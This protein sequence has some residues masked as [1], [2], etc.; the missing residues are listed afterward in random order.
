M[1]TKWF[2]QRI[3]RLHYLS[4]MTAK[5]VICLVVFITVGPVVSLAQITTVTAEQAPPIPGAGHDYIKL[6]NETVSPAVG[7]VDIRIDA[8][9]PLGRGGTVPFIIG[10]DTNSARHF[11]DG[12]PVAYDN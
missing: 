2:L 3:K 1:Q 8:G 9:T 11:N 7:A 10:Y 5:R 6:F 12:T 4:S